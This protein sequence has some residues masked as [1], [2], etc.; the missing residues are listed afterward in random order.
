M[1]MD[2]HDLTATTAENYHAFALMR[3][4]QGPIAFTDGHGTWI[5]WL[6]AE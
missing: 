5:H 3:D 2:G 4:G 1:F 6:A